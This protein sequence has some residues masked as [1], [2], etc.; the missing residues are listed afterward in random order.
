MYKI[1]GRKDLK[2]LL[3][4]IAKGRSGG[5]TGEQAVPGWGGEASPVPRRLTHAVCMECFI[6]SL[7]QPWRKAWLTVV[8]GATPW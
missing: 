5:R 6:T 3:T 8:G 2:N 4:A 1:G 7:R